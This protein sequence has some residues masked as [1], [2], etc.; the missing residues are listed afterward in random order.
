MFLFISDT[1]GPDLFS[2][3]QNVIKIV[4][5]VVE[6]VKSTD[7]RFHLHTGQEMY[8]YWVFCWL[9]V[10]IVRNFRCHC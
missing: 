1:G 7:S 8:G 4:F 9:S 5:L 10:G 3:D 2:F 6:S